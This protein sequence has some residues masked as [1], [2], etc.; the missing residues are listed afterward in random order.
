VSD[1]ASSDDPSSP[2]EEPSGQA[3]GIPADYQD[4]IT[5]AKERYPDIG[6][7]GQG[8]MTWDCPLTE[9][10]D[11]D[12]R[13]MD[14]QLM[15]TFARLDDGIYEVQCEFYPPTPATL[16]FAQAEGEAEF[17]VLEESTEAFEQA[18]NEQD[19]EEFTVGERTISVVTWTYPT[20]PEAGTKYVACYLDEAMLARACL[21]VA[22][23]DE[24]SKDYDGGQA[25]DDLSAILSA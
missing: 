1:D 24:R 17:A 7:T 3:K 6:S 12:D 19:E 9:S 16:R 14:E 8:D 10:V 21:D 11:V 2:S 22:D 23:S 5:D 25:A 20:N 18:G 13:T 15:T 4:A